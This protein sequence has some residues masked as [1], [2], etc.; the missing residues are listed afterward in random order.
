MGVRR[1][2]LPVTHTP[3]PA[4]GARPAGAARL[5]AAATAVLLGLAGC[6]S[7]GSPVGPAAAGSSADGTPTAGAASPAPALS[8]PSPT[9]APSARPRPTRA[10][11]ANHP[12][13]STRPAA[14]TSPTPGP[15]PGPTGTSRYVFPV[16]GCPVSYGHY[17]HDYP[18]TDIFAAVGCPVVSPVT[19]TVDEVSY[20]DT[21]N[22]ATDV[23]AVRGGLSISVVGVDGVRYYG[24]HLS[25]IAPGI[26]PGLRVVA[27]QLLGRVGKT[28]D[29]RYTPSHLH[30]GISWPTPPGIWW[31]RRGEVYPWPYLDSWRAG[32]SLSP[33]P[34]VFALRAQVGV[35]PTCTHYC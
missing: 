15:L 29:A 27:G 24:S 33:A 35:V 10:A 17:H 21:W 26:R 19:G 3:R 28:G 16:A 18:A 6:G 11:A 25:A 23:P 7:S 12:G 20:V 9:P 4:A 1:R 2:E 31:V 5:A 32:G 14:R 30:F 34:A 8:A 22:P 13:T